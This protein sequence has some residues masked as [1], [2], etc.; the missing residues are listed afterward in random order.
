M[1]ALSFSGFSLPA[2]CIKVVH[3]KLLF[4]SNFLQQH[5]HFLSIHFRRSFLENCARETDQRI[6]NRA[7]C[8]SREKRRRFPMPPQVS[9]RNEVWSTN[10]RK[11]SILMTRHFQDHGCAS[12]W[13]KKSFDQSEALPRSGKWRVNSM[14][15]LCLFLRRHFAG[16]GVAQ[17]RLFSQTTSFRLYTTALEQSAR[18]KSLSY[19]TL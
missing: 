7:I 2:K 15:F 18:K 9:P 14:E 6:T 12:D 5:W 17:C 8:P 19:C 13:L 3:G 4:N 10:E 1:Q 11:N 16:G